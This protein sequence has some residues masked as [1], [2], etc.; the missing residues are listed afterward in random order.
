[1]SS[2]LLSN[3]MRLALEK[4]GAER[5]LVTDNNLAIVDT[6]NLEQADIMAETFLG[7]EIIRQAL[8]AGEAIIT[9]NAVSSVS[10]APL[11]N[12]SFSNL[13]VV[14]VIPI[15]E[16]GAVYLDQPIRGGIIPKETVDRLM[17]VGMFIA[18]DESERTEAE[19]SQLYQEV[20]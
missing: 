11:T 12:T 7:I 18:D 13:R 10:N 16:L 17:A 6:V 14:V 15:A 5:A 9:N 2:T 20:G 3:F 19:L 1:M 4:T 8:D